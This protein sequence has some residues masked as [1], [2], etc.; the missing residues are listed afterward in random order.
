MR[1]NGFPSESSRDQST[2]APLHPCCEFSEREEREDTVF[3]LPYPNPPNPSPPHT[4][5]FSSFFSLDVNVTF[6]PSDTFACAAVSG[7]G[8]MCVFCVTRDKQPPH[9][10]P[11]VCLLCTFV[12]STYCLDTRPSS[13]AGYVLSDGAACSLCQVIHG[14]GNTRCIQPKVSSVSAPSPQRLNK[15]KTIFKTIF[16]FNP[17]MQGGKGKREG[18]DW[19]R[20]GFLL[21]F[22]N[23]L[24]PSQDSVMH[25]KTQF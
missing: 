25:V 23:S 11:S 15:R 10:P 14:H 5:S 24:L 9:P 6:V 4:R 21:S 17:G 12:I 2:D 8:K 22:W 7:G 18:K 19:H 13:V 20:Y 1:N 3:T 16:S